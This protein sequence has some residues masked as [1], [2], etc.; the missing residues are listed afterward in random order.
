MR[1]IR[2]RPWP[3]LAVN[4]TPLIDVVFLI[5]IFFIIMINFSEMHIRDI[6]LPKADE[7]LDSLANKNIILPVIIKADKKIYLDR[8]IVDLQ[9]L[10]GALKKKK[11]AMK[12]FQIQIQ[13]DET[14]PY[15]IVKE[16]LQTLSASGIGELEFS[17]LKQSPEPLQEGDTP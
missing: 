3:A 9:T 10:P 1:A 12:D 2:K 14:V 16:I 6:N 17:T 13:A 4:M 5:I 7:A 11:A 8:A 15:E